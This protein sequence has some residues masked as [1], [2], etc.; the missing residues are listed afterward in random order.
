MLAFVGASLDVARLFQAWITIEAAA[1]DAA[2]YAATTP[3]TVDAGGALVDARRI[4]CL[5]A[6]GL[7][8][9]AAGSGTP[10]TSIETCASPSVTITSFSV[11]T[12]APGATSKYPIGSATVHV[13]LPFE[14]LFAYPFITQNGALTLGT[15][16]SFS[17]VRNR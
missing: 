6:Q 12:T 15:S 14:P 11:S 9:F 16:K 10:P 5:Q 13:S 2:E 4:V 7:P 1:R 17:I 8:G 3:T